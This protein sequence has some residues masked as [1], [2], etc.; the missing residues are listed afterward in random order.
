MLVERNLLVF[1][2]EIFLEF[3]PT[4]SLH[5]LLVCKFTCGKLSLFHSF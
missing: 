4:I 3:L 1:Y 2:L 5:F